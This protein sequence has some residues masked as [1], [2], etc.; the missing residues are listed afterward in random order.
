MEPAPS[1]DI[2]TCPLF[3]PNIN[4]KTLLN[5]KT[6]RASKASTSH[7]IM[8][9]NFVI[10]RTVSGAVPLARRLISA[11][12]RYNHPVFRR[13]LPSALHHY[14]SRPAPDVALNQ[15]LDSEIDCA[16]DDASQEVPFPPL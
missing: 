1:V 10:R 6:F 14:S 7:L 9:L 2:V 12:Q 8:A 13:A 5:P 16:R 15:F 4:P 11:S 3:L